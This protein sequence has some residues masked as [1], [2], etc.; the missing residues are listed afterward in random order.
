MK[1][2]TYLQIQKKIW[3]Y[4]LTITLVIIASLIKV[5][6]VIIVSQEI[7]ATVSVC[8]FLL[9]YFMLIR[10]AEELKK[11]DIHGI[12]AVTY[13]FFMLNLLSQL[14]YCS[15]VAWSIINSLSI[16]FLIF[17]MIDG[18][19]RLILS[20]YCKLKEIRKVNEIDVVNAESIVAIVTSLIAVV[21]SCV[22]LVI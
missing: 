13:A 4:A 19:I 22:E 5:G 1:R 11:K 10:I 21:I 20:L 16:M 3:F 17:F 9:A 14:L 7:S 18:I 12:Q 8:L 15:S 2:E 6:T